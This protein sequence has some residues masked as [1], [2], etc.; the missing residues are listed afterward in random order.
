M[1][2]A[3]DAVVVFTN[4]NVKDGAFT[5]SGSAKTT[6]FTST[7]V[8]YNDAADSYKPKV[9]YVEDA[10]SI[11]KYGYLE[12]KIAGLGITSRSQ[13]YRLGKWFLFTNQLETDFNSILK[14]V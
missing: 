12:K 3:R 11:R 13:A 5:Y 10:A 9:E 1:I 6:R 8:R 7:L 14:R 2:Q 4:A